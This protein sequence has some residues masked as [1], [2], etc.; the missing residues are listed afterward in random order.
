VEEVQTIPEGVEGKPYSMDA[1]ATR[2][3]VDRASQR[4]VE[5][6]SRL[7]RAR[8]IK[9]KQG[10]NRANERNAPVDEDLD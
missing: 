2:R 3:R 10:D 9:N 4:L 1:E 8:L 5:G 6:L 7:T